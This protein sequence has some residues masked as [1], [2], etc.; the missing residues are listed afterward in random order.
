M[1]R[2]WLLELPEKARKPSSI[3]V[4]FL[5]P[6]LLRFA[7]LFEATDR[8]DDGAKD[9]KGNRYARDIAPSQGVWSFSKFRFITFKAV[10]KLR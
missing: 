4:A 7:V 5:L 10:R 8:R 3:S 9:G 2:S 1:K 6:T